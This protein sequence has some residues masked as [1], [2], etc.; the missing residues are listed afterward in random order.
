MKRLAVCQVLKITRFCIACDKYLNLNFY[1]PLVRLRGI[2]DEVE[3]ISEQMWT[4][5]SCHIYLIFA[6]NSIYIY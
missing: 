6:A 4:H 5:V 1:N 3:I 2:I